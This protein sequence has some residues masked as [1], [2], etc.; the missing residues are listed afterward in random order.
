MSTDGRRRSAA[1]WI[2][3]WLAIAALL[4]S[5]VQAAPP[6]LSAHPLDSAGLG[7]EILGLS[8]RIPL[9]LVHGIL[10]DHRVWDAYAGD[11][12]GDA[13]LRRKFKPYYFEY[14]AF[15]SQILPGDPRTIRQIG[16]AFGDAIEGAALRDRPLS[17]VAHS[18]GGLVARSFMQEW[19]LGARR[20]GDRTLRL[21]TLAT[22]HHGTPIADEADLA[23][24]ADVVL[25]QSRDLA[26]DKFDGTDATGH[27]NAWLR[28]LN[29]S[30]STHFDTESCAT[31][32]ERQQPRFFERVV[33]IG[34]GANGTFSDSLL[35]LGALFLSR[36]PPV[37][38]F[39]DNDGVVSVPSA[40]FEGWPVLSRLR[41]GSCD[42]FR[43][44]RGECQPGG[45]SLFPRLLGP[46]AWVG[47]DRRSYRPDQ[48]IV[49]T[50]E[51]RAGLAGDTTGVDLFFGNVSEDGTV[52]WLGVDGR[53]TTAEVPAAVGWTVPDLAGISVAFTDGRPGR[54]AW[55]VR[56]V[57]PGTG[58]VDYSLAVYT[59]DPLAPPADGDV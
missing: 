12:T 54:H 28:C 23:T 5:T 38:H 11:V 40:L 2:A 53:W 48:P 10:S 26:W 55:L 29:D 16:A 9:V 20:G 32:A 13:F 57:R 50:F 33:A 52:W 3:V 35:Q 47:T 43:L 4:P 14:T 44:P 56:L 51:S 27:T 25:E 45:Q 24:L 46:L 8:E 22:P 17:I 7:E 34:A 21:T 1:R 19:T 31:D 58:I 6:V 42:H 39:A 59:I 30:P 49:L 18:M 37:G 15:Q 41:V 36:Q